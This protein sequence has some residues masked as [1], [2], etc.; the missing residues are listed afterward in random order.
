MIFKDPNRETVNLILTSG[1]L[2]LLDGSLD[3]R[4][5]AKTIFTP[6][7]KHN[8]FNDVIIKGILEKKYRKENNLEK[9]SQIRKS[10]DALLKQKKS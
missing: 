5:E 2:L 3:I 4:T 1:T 7:I 10:F 9:F 6:I 8:K